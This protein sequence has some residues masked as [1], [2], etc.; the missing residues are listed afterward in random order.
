MPEQTLE[1]D[2]GEEAAPIDNEE[3]TLQHH[4]GGGAW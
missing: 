2:I 1:M 4:W 3:A